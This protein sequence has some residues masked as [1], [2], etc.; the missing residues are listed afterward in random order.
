MGIE[1]MGIEMTLSYSADRIL[2]QDR[3][4]HTLLNTL[5]RLEID[6]GRGGTYSTDR[7]L[8]HDVAEHP[9]PTGN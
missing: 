3:A 8:T 2:F 4:E 6:L 1:R 5:C 7:K 9:L